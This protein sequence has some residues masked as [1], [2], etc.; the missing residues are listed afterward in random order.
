M[1]DYANEIIKYL[2][3]YDLSHIQRN[4]NKFSSYLH[5]KTYSN[6]DLN[7]FPLANGKSQVKQ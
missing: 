7:A 5:H 3:E 4:D 2:S 1:H 6:N